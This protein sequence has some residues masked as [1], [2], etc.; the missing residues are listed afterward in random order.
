MGF[1]QDACRPT[2]RGFD[3]F[4]GQYSGGGDKYSHSSSKILRAVLVCKHICGVVGNA[5]DFHEDVGLTSTN[6]DGEIGEYSAVSSYS[7]LTCWNHNYLWHFRMY[8]EK[9]LFIWLT[10]MMLMSPCTCGWRSKMS[11]VLWRFVGSE[12]TEILLTDTCLIGAFYLVRP[13]CLAS[14]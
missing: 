7:R 5:L 11:T 4:L 12:F 3:T 10:I 8:M 1:C 14:I 13:V 9:E 2:Y 6:L